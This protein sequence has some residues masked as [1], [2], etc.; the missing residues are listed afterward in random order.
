MKTLTSI[1][2]VAL[3]V[4]AVVCSTTAEARPSYDSDKYND[5]D[6]YS[7]DRFDRHSSRRANRDVLRLDI[8]VHVRGSDRIPLRKLVKQYHRI[9]LDQYRLKKV[10]VNNHRRRHAYANLQVGDYVTD[11]QRLRRGN[12]HITAPHRTNGRWILGVKHARIDNIRVVLE[13]KHGYAKHHNPRTHRRPWF[14]DVPRRW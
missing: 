3:I 6:N 11:R 8:P 10:V 1:A 13:P 7:S 2:T 12:N 14:A 5:R 9:N 4:S